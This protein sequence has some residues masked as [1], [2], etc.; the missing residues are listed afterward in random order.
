VT[1][2]ELLRDI[3][4]HLRMARG[5][6]LQGWRRLTALALEDARMC[7]RALAQLVPT[8]LRRVS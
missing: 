4:W 6:R 1:R 7:R 3:R 8:T 2:A 5:Y